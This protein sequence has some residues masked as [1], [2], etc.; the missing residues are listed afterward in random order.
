ML[1]LKKSQ[2]GSDVVPAK[3][4][5]KRVGKAEA[6]EWYGFVSGDTDAASI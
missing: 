4:E 5:V 2:A 3:R 6:E 1:G